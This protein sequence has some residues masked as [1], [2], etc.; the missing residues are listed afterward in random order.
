V[1]EDHV[2]KEERQIFPMIQDN[3][4]ED[5]LNTIAETLKT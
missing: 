5:V 2:R 1:L 4:S 3:C